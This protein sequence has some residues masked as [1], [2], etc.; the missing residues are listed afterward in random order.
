VRIGRDEATEPAI[1]TGGG[2]RD[3]AVRR[4]AGPEKADGGRPLLRSPSAHMMPYRTRIHRPFAAIGRKMPLCHDVSDD[5]T[6][7]E[8]A[9]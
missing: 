3:G 6:T 8:E 2:R 9:R 1:G 5:E 7:R 4:S